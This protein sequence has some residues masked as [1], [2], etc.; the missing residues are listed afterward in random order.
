MSCTL[1]RGTP[2]I[3]ENLLKHYLGCRTVAICTGKVGSESP[4]PHHLIRLY[5]T[6]VPSYVQTDHGTHCS[7]RR[8][9]NNSAA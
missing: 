5:R 4:P 6:Y 7:D 1:L 3:P 2:L 8:G 9:P